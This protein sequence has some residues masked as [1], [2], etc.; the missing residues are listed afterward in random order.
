M[1]TQKWRIGAT[2]AVTLMC[3]SL[4][5]GEGAPPPPASAGEVVFRVSGDVERPQ[6]WTMD[7]LATLPRHEIRARDRDGKEATFT[8]VALVDLL[9]L[10]G[11]PL[12]QE[13]RGQHLATYLLI[14]AADGYRVV[15]ALP[16]LDPAFTDRE[17]LL[18]DRR[19]G[20]PLAAAEGPLRLVVPGEKRH[21]R[22]IRQVLS[23][24][25]RRAP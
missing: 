17:V 25:I 14:E 15:F 3:G 11:V 22:W 18:A 9:R 13:L 19:D 23:C 6:Q 5:L 10:A 2:F 20:Q 24:T 21:A 4:L 8:G 16:E 1:L 7:D 12:G